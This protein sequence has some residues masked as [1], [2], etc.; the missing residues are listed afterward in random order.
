MASSPSLLC[1]DP[2][3]ASVVKTSGPLPL[4]S[5]ERLGRYEAYYWIYGSGFSV[6]R[7]S[8]EGVNSDEFVMRMVSA[9]FACHDNSSGFSYAFARVH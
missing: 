7:R 5:L 9:R 3:A 2:E 4:A 8:E 6:V 1:A